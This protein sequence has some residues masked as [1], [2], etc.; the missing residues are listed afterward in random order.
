MVDARGQMKGYILTEIHALCHRSN[1]PFN[2]LGLKSRPLGADHTVTSPTD[3][4]VVLGHITVKTP[5]YKLD[6]PTS[7]SW[8]IDGDHI[9]WNSGS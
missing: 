4:F 7:T 5:K 9:N 6:F 1:A 8:L 3:Y 2:E